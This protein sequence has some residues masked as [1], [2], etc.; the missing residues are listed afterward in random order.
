MPRGDAGDA[1]TEGFVEVVANCERLCRTILGTL[2]PARLSPDA[3][4]AGTELV[5][6]RTAL[7]G[8]ILVQ[9][10]VQM[11]SGKRAVE[12]DEHKQL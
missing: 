2:L 4:P 12:D 1:P 9:I 3:L 8:N 10:R 11:R 6:R 5:R 7:S